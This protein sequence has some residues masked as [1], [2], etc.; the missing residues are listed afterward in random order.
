MNIWDILILAIVAGMLFLA[1]R[2]VRKGNTG[3]CHNCSGSGCHGCS[4]S[5]NGCPGN[6]NGNSANGNGCPGCAGKYE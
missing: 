4:G 3:S 2:A 1:F 6:E 5:G